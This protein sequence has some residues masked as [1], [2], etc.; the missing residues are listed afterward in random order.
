MSTD[1]AKASRDAKGGPRRPQR[2]AAEWVVFAVSALLILAVTAVLVADW[3]LGPSHPPT[4][5]T[6]VK[7]VRPREGAYQV[8]VEVENVGNQ[9]AADVRVDGELETGVEVSEAQETIDFLAPGE[10]TTVTFVFNRD[11]GKGRLSV[12]VNAF[13]EP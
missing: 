2:T 10:K 11:P 3:A 7:T 6:T 13:R 1:T 5:R 9:A 8:P 4:F 12:S